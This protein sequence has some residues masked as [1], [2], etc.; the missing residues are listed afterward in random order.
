MGDDGYMKSKN[1][2]LN[3]KVFKVM[4]YVFFITGVIEVAIG[5][6]NIRNYWL[7]A[8]TQLSIGAALLIGSYEVKN[9]VIYY[10]QIPLLIVYILCMV[11]KWLF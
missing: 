3:N 1:F 2:V 10:L 4:G 5:L 6:L 9:K 11:A 8:I 7:D